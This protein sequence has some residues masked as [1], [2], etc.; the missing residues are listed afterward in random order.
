MLENKKSLILLCIGMMIGFILSWIKIQFF[1]IPTVE[2]SNC[3]PIQKNH[4][5]MTIDLSQ[6]FKI[7]DIHEKKRI[8]TEVLR[9][10]CI[11]E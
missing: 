11:N 8:E 9:A 4:Q 2:L 1:Y 10:C 6:Y 5:M 3:Q 7:K